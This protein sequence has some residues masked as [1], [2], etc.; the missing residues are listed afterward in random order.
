VSLGRDRERLM[1]WVWFIS[2]VCLFFVLVLSVVFCFDSFENVH[3]FCF[4]G[5]LRSVLQEG[6]YRQEKDQQ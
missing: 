4:D 1:K 6:V 5:M 2:F 3:F